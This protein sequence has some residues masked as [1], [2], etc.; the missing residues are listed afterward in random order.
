MIEKKVYICNTCNNSSDGTILDCIRK[1]I[2]SR[3]PGCY[4]ENGMTKGQILVEIH[5]MRGEYAHKMNEE[6]KRIGKMALEGAQ[7]NLHPMHTKAYYD[8]QAKV[9]VLDELLEKIANTSEDTS[10]SK[11]NPFCNEVIRDAE[12]NEIA[13]A[14]GV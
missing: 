12:G 3:G 11:H 2:E 13:R 7:I 1:R 8:S 14:K 5:E 9:M 10:K 6:L 4:P